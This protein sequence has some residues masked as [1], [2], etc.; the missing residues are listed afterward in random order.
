MYIHQEKVSFVFTLKGFA[1]D[2]LGFAFCGKDK[3]WFIF[4]IAE[5]SEEEDC[6]TRGDGVI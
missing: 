5:L 2:N 3:D 6:I 1:G 4:V